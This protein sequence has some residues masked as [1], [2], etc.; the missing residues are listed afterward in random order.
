[1]AGIAR[2]LPP[3]L[4][5]PN[6]WQKLARFWGVAPKSTVFS[7]WEALYAI[8]PKSTVFSRWEALYAIAEASGLWSRSGRR[9][10]PRQRRVVDGAVFAGARPELRVV[11]EPVVGW[12]ASP[13]VYR[14]AS[15]HQIDG[16]NWHVFGGWHQSPQF[17]RAGR[18]CTRSHQ[19]P[20]F[21]RAGRLC[22][23]S[24]RRV[25]F[26]AGAGGGQ[27]HVSAASSMVQFLRAPVL[28]C[29]SSLSR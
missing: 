24:R 27:A 1:M 25:G 5:A 19:S 18:L 9:A 23:R 28:S 12:P 10:G 2:R 22:T 3:R 6:R 20:Q 26:G 7:R 21:F 17:F 8:A 14:R 13:A 16:K 11:A 15:R 4:Q 29:G